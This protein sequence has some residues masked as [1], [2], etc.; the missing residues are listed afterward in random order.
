MSV[1]KILSAIFTVA[2]TASLTIGVIDPMNF[3]TVANENF[4]TSDETSL[5]GLFMMAPTFGEKI[6][7]FD[8]HTLFERM[9][10]NIPAE[11]GKNTSVISFNPQPIEIIP[12]NDQWAPKNEQLVVSDTDNVVVVTTAS[13]L[14]SVTDVSSPASVVI[15]TPTQE[16]KTVKTLAQMISNL[17]IQ[18]SG[19]MLSATESAH[20]QQT[21]ADAFQ[22]FPEKFTKP[23]KNLT[24]KTSK[25]G[26]R[27][28]AG[29][30]TM[31]L[32]VSDM[33]D[34]ELVGVAIHELGHVI[35]LGYLTGHG[36]GNASGFMDGDTAVLTDDPS[37]EFY[38]ISWT[39]AKDKISSSNEGFVSGYASSDPFED[40]A[41]T[42]NYYVL[43]ADDFKAL[44]KGNAQ[45]SKKYEFMK[46]KV[47]EGQEF[48]H[49]TGKTSYTS[50][51]P[52]D[53]TV[54]PYD[55]SWYQNAEF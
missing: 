18:D 55:W 12:D 5:A 16:T 39:S 34:S 25:D 52:W 54:I 10:N 21:L 17:S 37:S 29:S 27:G 2:I 47:F 22:K 45:L 36:T 24:L 8:A 32:R 9:L 31:I 3:H 43:H 38:A 14:S 44:A 20:I 19:H 1:K 40:F 15:T 53:T 7:S 11:K 42:F 26:P 35:D 30:N 23:L 13:M 6:A 50:Y 49:T 48:T 28:L 51:R 4:S 46:N 33:K 41:E